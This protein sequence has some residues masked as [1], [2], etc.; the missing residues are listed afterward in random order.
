MILLDTCTLLWLARNELP[1]SL[2]KALHQGPWC[3]SS[4]TAWEIGIKTSNGKLQLPL[5]IGD[6]W[7][8]I[9]GHFQIR[10][11]DFGSREAI[12]ATQLPPHHA[13]PFDRGI[14]ATAMVAQ[15]PVATADRRLLEYRAPGIE[16]VGI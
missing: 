8:E 11:L 9:L 4:L 10:E 14:L 3:V 6:W 13:D 12:L 7:T 15:I 2:A 1:P 16:V 5:P